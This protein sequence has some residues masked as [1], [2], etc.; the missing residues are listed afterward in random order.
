MQTCTALAGTGTLFNLMALPLF[1]WFASKQTGQ[2]LY[3]LLFVALLIWSL[4]VMAHIFKHAL[5]ISFPASM[6]VSIL[7]I[8]CMTA[9]NTMIF[10]SAVLQ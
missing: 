3:L 8:L 7:L 9:L 5:A 2:A 4:S 10:P 6:M 1:D